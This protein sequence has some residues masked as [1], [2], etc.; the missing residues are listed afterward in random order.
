MF[1]GSF[2][3]GQSDGRT[4]HNDF[5]RV[6]WYGVAG[7]AASHVG[8]ATHGSSVQE[9]LKRPEISAGIFR[10]IVSSTVAFNVVSATAS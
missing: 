8:S 7:P 6:L 3:G 2:T 9:I 4:S 5:F 1:D 10:V